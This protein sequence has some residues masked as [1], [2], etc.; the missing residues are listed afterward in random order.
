MRSAS[1]CVSKNTLPIDA[2]KLKMSCMKTFLP[3]DKFIT[4]EC[5]YVTCADVGNYNIGLK[6]AH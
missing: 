5:S 4:H 6:V 3:K 2:F 1:D